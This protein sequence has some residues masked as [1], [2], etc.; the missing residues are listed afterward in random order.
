LDP[1]YIVKTAEANKANL[2]ARGDVPQQA[3]EQNY[4]GTIDY[5][6]VF[7]IPVILIMNTIFGLVVGLIGGLIFKKSNL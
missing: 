6:W 1:E 7:A 4:Q 3:I 2:E 5:F